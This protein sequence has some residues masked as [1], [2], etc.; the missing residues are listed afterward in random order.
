MPRTRTRP[1]PPAPAF[2]MYRP[3]T[4]TRSPAT[5]FSHVSSA[6]PSIPPP[7]PLTPHPSPLCASSVRAVVVSA[8]LGVRTCV[9][10]ASLAA[11]GR[12]RSPRA[13]MLSAAQR[14]LSSPHSPQYPL[15]HYRPPLC[16]LH[17]PAPP[18]TPHPSPLT[19]RY[20]IPPAAPTE[21]FV[22]KRASPA[23]GARRAPPTFTPSPPHP[24]PLTPHLSPLCASSVR[25][26]VVSAS[27][28]V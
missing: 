5:L 4:S 11:C 7:S 23:A 15:P 6:Q 18:L 12:V 14:R 13:P 3:R 8:S 1:P 10:A 17:H 28:G 27:L 21:I 16:V 24:S 25:A 2:L 19:P 22:G 9:V 26:V 20:L